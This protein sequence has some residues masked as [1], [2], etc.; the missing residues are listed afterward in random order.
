VK[1]GP[2]A[3]LCAVERRDMLMVGQVSIMAACPTAGLVHL[4][5][6]FF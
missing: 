2:D 4:H 1:A 3:G 6:V 5:L